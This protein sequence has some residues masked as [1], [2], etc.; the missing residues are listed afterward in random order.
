M[1]DLRKPAGRTRRKSTFVQEMI[2]RYEEPESSRSK[3][4]E[5]PQIGYPSHKPENEGLEMLETT[6][7]QW[8]STTCRDDE[9][10]E[11]E[12]TTEV[13]GKSSYN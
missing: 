10:K 8:Q 5:M 6:R 12:T 11:A 3:P 1:G 4:F 9:T 7:R 13:S 2:K